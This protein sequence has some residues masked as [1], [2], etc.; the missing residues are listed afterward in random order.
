M[1]VNVEKT[2]Y[3]AQNTSTMLSLRHVFS[4]LQVLFIISEVLLY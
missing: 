2:E 4:T 1:E 3:Q